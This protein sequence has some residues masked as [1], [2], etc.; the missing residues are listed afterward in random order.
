MADASTTNLSLTKPESGSSKGTWGAKLNANFDT[1]DNAVI[2][3]NTQTLTNKTLTDCL[4][5]T[6]SASDNSTK[7]ATTAY[8]DSQVTASDLDFQGDSG[9]ALSIDLDSEV[10]DIAGGTGI[11]TTGSGNEVSVAIDSTV[12][13]LTGSQTLTNKTLTAPTLTTP[14]LGTPASGVA[15]NLT[16]TASGLTAGNVTTN[17]NLT[18]GVTSVG[19]AATVVTNANLTGDVTSVGNATA[20]ASDTIINADVKSD[21]AIAISKTA[22]V[23]GTG[24]TLSTNT[25]NVDAAQTQI[26]SVG[27]IGAGTWEGTTVAVAQGGT[28]VTSKTGTGSVVL[29]TSPTL[30]TPALGTP[31][32]GVM[33][34]VTGNAS[35]LTSGTATTATNVTASANDSTDE[36]TYPVFVDGATGAQGIETDTGFTYNPSTGSLTA[37]TFTGALTGTA[38][39]VTT[40]ANLTGDVTSV[41]N[42]TAIATGVIIDADVNSSAAIA[43][44]KTALV[45]G[46]G[47]TLSTNTLN[48]DAA[49]TQ[50][51]SVGALNAGS[52]T[53]GFTSI[54]VGSGAITTTGTATATTFVG[55]LTGVA[56]GNDVLGSAVSMAIALG[57]VLT[58]LIG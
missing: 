44:S 26:T 22:L 32:S 3:T 42:A 17:A 1:L 55:A 53:S 38:S 36:T 25:L 41:G 20:I 35:G 48:V 12:T 49:Q 7:L 43:I 47:L 34:N 23:G 18:G 54:D 16:G 6:Q 10:L 45:G 21:A 8:V 2:L 50:I 19:N 39:S 5:N 33:T 24:L 27:T 30:V 14:A 9:G 51:T 56:S 11:D 4:A 28:G 15:T 13:T 31:A 52:I 58:P 46:T 37:T 57:V 40:N 29:S